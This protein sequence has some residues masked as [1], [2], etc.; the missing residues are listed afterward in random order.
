MRNGSHKLLR[1]LEKPRELL[2]STRTSARPQGLIIP[3]REYN[4]DIARNFGDFAVGFSAFLRLMSAYEGYDTI[5]KF[6]NLSA[7]QSP[8]TCLLFSDAKW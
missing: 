8:R 2:S 1:A 4:D 3:N 7:L 6:K 5:L